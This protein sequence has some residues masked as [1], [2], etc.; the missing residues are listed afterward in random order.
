MG[1]KERTVIAVEREGWITQ[2]SFVGGKSNQLDSVARE[3]RYG[4]ER[5]GVD[6]RQR[7]KG[8][9]GVYIQAQAQQVCQL[10]RGCG[11]LWK[12]RDY[13]PFSPLTLLLLHTRIPL[14]R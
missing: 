7:E 9:G 1:A 6:G 2:N 10:C 5:G 3:K 12:P 14:T 11:A 4:I 13:I 8:A